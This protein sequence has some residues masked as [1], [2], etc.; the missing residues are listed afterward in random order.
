MNFRARFDVGVNDD[1]IF[2]ANKQQVV[3]LGHSYFNISSCSHGV[4]VVDL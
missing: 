2:S 4:K 3:V 1:S